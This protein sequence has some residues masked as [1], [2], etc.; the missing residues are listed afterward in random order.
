VITKSVA[1]DFLFDLLA[2]KNGI[3]ASFRNVARIGLDRAGE[4]LFDEAGYEHDDPFSMPPQAAIDYL[5]SRENRLASASDEVYDKIKV[6]L[7]EGIREG[8]SMSKLADRVKSEFND[9]AKD[10]AMRIA[11]TETSAVYGVARQEA[12]TQAG[13]EYK[14]WLTSGLPNVR[15]AHAAA[16][17][18]TVKVDEPF[19]V[20][21][22]RLMHPGD[23]RG[24]AGNVINC[25]CVSIAVKAPKGTNA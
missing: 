24:S 9:I 6:Q 17:G 11:S 23:P 3:L 2:F 22:E 14:Q 8:E 1:S 16:E 12:M 5:Q 18:E 13:I 15:P 4:E 7:E 21:G 20:G 19:L 10:D 25:H